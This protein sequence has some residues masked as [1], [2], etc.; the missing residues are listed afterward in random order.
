M[1]ISN[2]SRFSQN[3]NLPKHSLPYMYYYIFTYLTGPVL[4]EFIMFFCTYP[5]FIY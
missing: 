4:N 2:F 5:P 3:F 1:K